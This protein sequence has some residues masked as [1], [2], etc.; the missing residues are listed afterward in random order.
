[1]MTWILAYPHLIVRMH[2]SVKSIHRHEDSLWIWDNPL[3]F[4]S[5]K[6]RMKDNTIFRVS[7]GFPGGTSGKE[8]TCQCRRHK[9]SRV[10][11]WGG[12]EALDKEMAAH[13]STL[14]WRIPWTEKLDGL[15]SIGLQRTGHNLSDLACT[16]TE[17][18]HF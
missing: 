10:N 13:S 3:I 18:L 2:L 8:Y 14:A 11:P 1:M 5:M 9:R 4:V 7:S 12:K 6:Q 16:H 17:Y 15:R